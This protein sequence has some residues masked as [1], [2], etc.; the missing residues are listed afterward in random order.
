MLDMGSFM[1]AYEVLCRLLYHYVFGR[2]ATIWPVK[3]NCMRSDITSLSHFL[4]ELAAV[5]FLERG[6]SVVTADLEKAGPWE[7]AMG[8]VVG[9]ERGQR[10]KGWT[11]RRER[12]KGWKRRRG[13]GGPNRKYELLL[14]YMYMYISASVLLRS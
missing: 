13:L 8:P 11:R 2:C 10:R 4:Q 3:I 7:V 14:A 9:M 12:R 5:S 6:V 1:V